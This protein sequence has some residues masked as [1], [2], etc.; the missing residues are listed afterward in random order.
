METQQITEEDIM[1]A[2]RRELQ[3]DNL[4][5]VLQINLERTGKISFI[6]K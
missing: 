5:A 2:C 6:K 4:D 1:E 3:C